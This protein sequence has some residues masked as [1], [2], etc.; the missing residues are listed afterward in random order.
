MS[1]IGAAEINPQ[2]PAMG[3]DLLHVE[4]LEAMLAC[5]P[6]DRYERK[7][8]EMLVIDGIKLIL[9]NE[10]LEMRKLERDHSL[11]REQ[12][13]HTRGEIVEIR[14][15]GQDIVADDE[16]GASPLGYQTFRK[17]EP[18]KLHQGRNILFPCNLRDIGRRLDAGH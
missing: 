14:N 15:L 3:R 5:E 2:R 17:S 6:I 8:R 11:R 16:I 12:M 4:Q 10:P 9:G 1:G 18:E 13:R 7:I